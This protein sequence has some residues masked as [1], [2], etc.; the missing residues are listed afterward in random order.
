MRLAFLALLFAV[1]CSE[2]PVEV[3]TDTRE[4]IEIKYVGPAEL[5]VRAAPA[6]TAELITKY[7]SGEAVSIVAKQGE[8]A[9]IRTGVGTGWVQY[10]SL[11]NA[12]AAKAEED[13]PQPRFL[14]T[15][16]PVTA[17]GA[18]GEIYIEA[19]VNT[20]GKVTSTRLLHNTTG[21]EALAAQN[22]AALQRAQ[23]HPIVQKGERKA[24]K[25]YHRVTY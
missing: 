20:D 4:P 13:N 23:F 15:P 8:W 2:A 17:P 16:M 1:A 5:E 22:A 9:E 3:V 6:A 12:E 14:R 24:F 21:S 25:Y 18:H 19:D 11:T 10:A 7:Q